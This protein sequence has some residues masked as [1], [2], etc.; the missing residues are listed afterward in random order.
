MCA[1]EGE[2]EIGT[3][4]EEDKH[5]WPL[6]RVGR[7]ERERERVCERKRERVIEREEGC[8]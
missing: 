5:V 8:V 3:I 7:R 1:R 6:L 4:G 2:G